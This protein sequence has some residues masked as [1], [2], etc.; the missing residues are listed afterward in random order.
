MSKPEP[1][2]V[3]SCDV[4]P[5]DTHLEGYGI[6][7]SARCDLVYRRAVPRL[8]E[9]LDEIGVR[10]VFFLVGRDAKQQG[11]LLR[12]IV[13]AGHEVASHSMNHPVPFRTLSEE[14]LVRE[15]RDSRSLLSDASGSDVLGFRAPA[16]D[17]DARVLAAVRRAGYRYDASV[18]PSPALVTNRLAV[19]WRGTHKRSLFSM[20]LFAHA[21]ASRRPRQC[22]GAARG[23]T[24]FPIAV[25]SRLRVPVYHTLSHLTPRWLFDRVLRAAARS[26][27]PLCYGL[28]AVD[29]L[30][31]HGDG[32][33]PRLARHP[34]MALPLTVKRSG[35]QSVLAAIARAR[36]V[37]TYRQALVEGLA[38]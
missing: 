36:Q 4:D 38:P 13:A 19:Y 7:G 14:A 31:L 3:L 8:L 12:T 37:V 27:S 23:L 26:P 30:D 25:T 9:L 18:F 11:K 1:Y 20:D 15:T 35:L 34:G 24:E 16:W 28:H 17:V 22:N 32:M 29:L 10:A 33:D 5:V 21:L 6:T 2:A